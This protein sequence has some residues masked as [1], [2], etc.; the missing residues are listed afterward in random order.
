M[1]ERLTAEIEKEPKSTNLYFP[2]RVDEKG[3]DDWEDKAKGQGLKVET[4]AALRSIQPFL[5]DPE[6]GRNVL[7]HVHALDIADKHKRILDPR[8]QPRDA[9][10]MKVS[11]LMQP[12]P[13]S[14]FDVVLHNVDVRTEGTIVEITSSAR[15]CTAVAAGQ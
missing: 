4:I 9:G 5:A 1:R 13:A 7:R 14:D 11:G 8:V 15:L 10:P 12:E 2:I 6:A 3:F